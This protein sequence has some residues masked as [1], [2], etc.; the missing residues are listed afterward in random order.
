MD[1]KATDISGN[2]DADKIRQICS[3]HGITYTIESECRGGLVL[4]DVKNKR[5][6]LAH[7]TT[8]FAECGRYYS[9]EDLEKIKKETIIFLNSI[10]KGM[11]KY[12]DDKTFLEVVNN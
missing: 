2:L 10:L 8:S 4:E 1:R 9:I 12:Y 6:Q 11:K 5:N 3:E 7:G